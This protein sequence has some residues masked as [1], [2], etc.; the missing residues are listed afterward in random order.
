MKYLQ[1]EK[2]VEIGILTINRPDALNALNIAVLEEI[3]QLLTKGL[4]EQEI[5]VL[6]VTG[7]GEKA[8]IAGADI[9]AM[10][11]LNHLEMLSFLELGQKITFQLER[12]D[13][14]TIAAVNGFALGGGL[15]IA[16]A[17]DF[18]FASS[19]AKMGLP[20]VTLGLIPGFGGTQ[21]LAR[22]IG[23]RRAKELIITGNFVSAD[24][25]EKI[26]LVNK[27]TEPA[28]LLP[29]CLAVAE[30]ICKNSFFSVLKAKKVIDLGY[31]LTLVEAMEMEKYTC[32]ICF[33][34][35]NCKEGM[36]AFLNKRKPDFH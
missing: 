11:N 30:K 33:T 20:E 24:I 19:T 34:T 14:V 10:N 27:V 3:N 31:N 12:S 16:L 32:T 17:C 25:A 1:F 6:I 9:K 36:D 23:G 2:R 4:V 8:F 13:I 26:G 22:A 21:R 29:E 5:K 7:A 35:E 18:I 15:E 28:Q